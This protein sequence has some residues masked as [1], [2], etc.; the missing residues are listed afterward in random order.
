MSR[1]SWGQ[2]VR[3]SDRG[4][5]IENRMRVTRG[6]YTRRGWGLERLGSKEYGTQFPTGM[7]SKATPVLGQQ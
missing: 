7:I 1:L 4:P 3:G 6:P 2:S 5:G